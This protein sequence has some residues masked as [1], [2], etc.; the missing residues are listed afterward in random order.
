MTHQAIHWAR[1]AAK[2]DPN[3]ITILVI[4]DNNWYQNFAPYNGPFPDTH[5]MTHF[6]A[7]TITY[8]EPINPQSNKTPRIE[9]LAIRILCV[10][11]QNQNFGTPNQINTLKTTIENLQISQHYVQITPPTPPNT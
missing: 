5:V 6:A 9:P 3:T 10:H 7:D 11:H 4:P 8:E 1:L 2:N